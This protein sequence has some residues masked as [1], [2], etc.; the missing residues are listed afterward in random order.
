MR[1]VNARSDELVASDVTL[2]V[3]RSDRRQGLLGRHGLDQGAAL[4]LSPCWSI[5]TM[6]MRFSIDAVFVDREG[7][8][9]KT[10]GDL[11]PWR[12][13]VAPRAH[14]V[15]ELKA[16]SIKAR[17]IRIGDELRLIPAPSPRAFSPLRRP[18]PS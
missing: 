9:V 11:V 6:F 1:L 15:I 5:H 10:V 16:G 12:I 2:A 4:V 13:A 14:A 17:D 7:R 8:A 18:E 3:T